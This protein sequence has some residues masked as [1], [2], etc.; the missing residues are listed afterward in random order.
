VR[1]GLSVFIPRLRPEFHVAA[2]AAKVV[3][4]YPDVAGMTAFLL[5]VTDIVGLVFVY[6]I[7][8]TVAMTT[9]SNQ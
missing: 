2:E 5:L 7:G 4:S 1:K 3:S 6:C 9:Q 8:E